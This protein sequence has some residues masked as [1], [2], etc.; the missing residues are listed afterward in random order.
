MI[1]ID[2]EDVFELGMDK[3]GYPFFTIWEIGSPEAIATDYADIVAEG[4]FLCVVTDTEAWAGQKVGQLSPVAQKR[5][6]PINLR[7]WEYLAGLYAAEMEISRRAFVL[8]FSGMR[9]RLAHTPGQWFPWGE[10]YHWSEGDDL[11]WSALVHGHHS[12]LKV[13]EYEGQRE[14]MCK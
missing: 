7:Q 3:L 2:R 5:A 1:L 4:P 8:R 14:V 9:R 11:M 6:D 12:W 13:R 10:I